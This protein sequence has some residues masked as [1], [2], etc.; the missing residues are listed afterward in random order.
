MKVN[1]Q[2][3]TYFLTDLHVVHCVELT[4]LE[5]KLGR[6]LM[7]MFLK[8][9]FINLLHFE[10]ESEKRFNSD[11]Y[12]FWFVTK[13]VDPYYMKSI[14]LALKEGQ[15]YTMTYVQIFCRVNANLCIYFI[16][17]HNI[18]HISV[19]YFIF[20]IQQQKLFRRL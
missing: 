7:L 9:S 19:N 3:C 17:L 4:F 14:P 1:A 10:S 6:C 13:F 12:C 16:I 2:V 11:E 18:V 15:F 20:K 8:W 5:G